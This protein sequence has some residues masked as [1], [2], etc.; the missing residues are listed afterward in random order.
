[1]GP[2]TGL[3]GIPEDIRGCA[4]V[5]K[6][7]CPS[8]T[9]SLRSGAKNDGKV[10]SQGGPSAG[11]TEARNVRG[12]WPRRFRRRNSAAC[13]ARPAWPGTWQSRLGASIP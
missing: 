9:G 8:A 2:V 13:Y 7:D 4:P 5:N 11:R 3:E 6:L 1:M 12:D 10:G